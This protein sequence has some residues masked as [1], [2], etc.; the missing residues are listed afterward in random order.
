MNN[1]LL[2]I[3]Y[4]KAGSSF[5]GDWFHKHPDIIF[6]DFSIGGFYNTHQLM[7]AALNK[8]DD[9][10]KIRIVRDMRFTAP[11]TEN[12]KNINEIETAQ[13]NIAYTLHS[14]FPNAKVLIVT[15]GYES[16]IKA[17]YSQYIKEGGIFSFNKLIEK[18]KNS[19]WLPYNY[20]YI[21]DLYSKLFDK[22]NI[23]ILPFE[24]LK[25]EPNNFLIKIE[26]FL[27]INHFDYIT[28]VINPSLTPNSIEFVRKINKCIYYFLFI[29]GPF[30]KL[31]YKLYIRFIK[32]YNTK[33]W[34]N[35]FIKTIATLFN[36]S[37]THYIIPVETLNKFSEF[38]KSLKDNT[39]YFDLK[40]EYFIK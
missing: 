29:Y 38:S 21:I 8:V 35:Y 9:A 14:L 31:A 39:N 23:L 4:P 28:K 22:K 12:F 10:N 13:K 40:N 11:N 27:K 36:S 17:N 15:R 32:R 7:E 25:K 34:N 2:H 26:S 6:R 20:S 5:L 1:I 30:Q 24:M 19:K 3:G 18:H 37:K 33:S 16:V